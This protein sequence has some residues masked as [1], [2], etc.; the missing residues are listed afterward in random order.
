MPEV[1]EPG[2]V[3]VAVL[4]LLF[5]WP[6]TGGGNM[7]TAGL[8]EFLGR[9]GFEVRHFYAAYRPWGIGRDTR[10]DGGRRAE[11]GGKAETFGRGDGGVGDP[12]R[13]DDGRAR[14]GSDD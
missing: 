10:Q 3:R 5:N 9:D 6:S 4:S 14:T 7:H 8:V 13:T 1:R 12:R 11:D 2:P